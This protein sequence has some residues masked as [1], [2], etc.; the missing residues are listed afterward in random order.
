MTGTEWYMTKKGLD[1]LKFVCT[2]GHAQW[3][4]RLYNKYLVKP[5]EHFDGYK[6]QAQDNLGIEHGR[7]RAWQGTGTWQLHP[8]GIF[9]YRSFLASLW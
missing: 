8:A 9:S 2:R 6:M 4:M 3:L 1:V 5:A 7:G